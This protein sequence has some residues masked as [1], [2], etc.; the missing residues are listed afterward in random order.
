MRIPTAQQSIDLLGGDTELEPYEV[1]D[2][3]SSRRSAQ[4][5]EGRQGNRR[6]PPFHLSSAL[7][8]EKHQI[9]MLKRDVDDWHYLKFAI[10]HTNMKAEQHS[11][12]EAKQLKLKQQQQQ[13]QQQRQQRRGMNNM[14]SA[15]LA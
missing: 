8:P 15:R 2:R 10:E 3:H 9:E 5:P 4:L 14:P 7:D 12:A 11:V 13:Q 1:Y 6:Q